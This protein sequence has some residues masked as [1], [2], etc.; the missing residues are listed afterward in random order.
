MANEGIR[1]GQ[2]YVNS[3]ICSPSRAAIS[4]GQ[5]P[6]RH[7]ITSYL[8]HRKDNEERGIAN[9]LDPKAP[10]LARMLKQAGYATGHFGKWHM[11]GQ[12]DVTDALPITAY[13]FDESLTN[14]EGLGPKLLPLTEVPTEDGGIKKGRIWEDAEIL[15]EPA[16]WMLRSKITSG[17]VD[18]SIQFIDRAQSQKKPFYINL[19]PD[20]VHSP[21]FPSVKHWADTKEGLYLSV[22]EEMDK[23]FAP[24][25]ER[26]KNDPE[27]SQ[28][29]LIVI[30]SD[31]GPEKG[32]GSAGPFRGSK[33]TLYE[34]GIRS[35]LIVW[36]PGFVDKN[37]VGTY[38]DASVI[39]AID[40]VPS[41]LNLAGISAPE[42]VAF[43]GEN[44]SDT[45]LGK[46]NNS[47]MS[48]IFF[49]RPPDRKE[50]RGDT[51]LPDFA[52]RVDQWKLLC[53]YG[54]VHA[55]LYDV[56]TDPGESHNLADENPD[57][58]KRCG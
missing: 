11:G 22:V 38:N 20:D 31:N 56:K 32:A 25:F 33:A 13:G 27:L 7:H 42:D 39:A 44:L 18:R 52:V 37:Q 47:R 54:G 15:G 58:T 30:C 5:Y 45:L 40:L 34:G 50:Y 17:F 41:L 49:R 53:D 6:Q 48:P 24:I 21:F 55:Q 29:T 8:A 26:I 36:G 46:S 23:Q 51:N 57:V 4:T 16:T 19:W 35:P 43:D 14:F 10:M 1:F 3:P 9:W 2:F 12:R 28:N